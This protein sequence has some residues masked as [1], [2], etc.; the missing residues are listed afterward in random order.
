MKELDERRSARLTEFQ[1]NESE[2]R[3]SWTKLNAVLQ[4]MSEGV[5]AIDADEKI[6]FANLAV[7]GMLDF[8]EGQVE[9]RLLFEVA[10]NSHLQET[11]KQ[12]L[13]EQKKTSVEFK[14]ARTGSHLSLVTSPLPTGGAVL[15]LADV[16]G[17]R[18]LENMRRDFVGGVS[19]EL[20]TPLTVIQACTETLLDGA[21]TD[22]DAGP[23]FLRQIEEQ[24]E[25]LLHLIIA[26]M[27]LAR[28]ESGE[29]VFRKEP[30]DL[31]RVVN[32]VASNMETVA[33][34]RSLTLSVSGADEL[35]VLADFQA[36]RTIISNLC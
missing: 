31:R 36:V 13:E 7:C 25:R 29:Q 1:Q 18:K 8:T 23:R 22:P 26:M 12:S 9:G 14:V 15:V 34:N 24:S 16:T 30:V 5:V 10:R 35:F 6:Q 32:K 3:E 21:I 11:V 17:V 27:E 4:A 28:L 33:S 20:K 2:F 19:H